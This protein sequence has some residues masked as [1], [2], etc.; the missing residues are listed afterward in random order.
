[1]AGWLILDGP[2]HLPMMSG[3]VPLPRLLAPALEAAGPTARL[4]LNAAEPPAWALAGGQG[5][6]FDPARAPSPVATP[7]LMAIVHSVLESPRRPF[8]LDWHLGERD[9]TATPDTR[10]RE[11]LMVVARAALESRAVAFAFDRERRPVALGPG[12][13]RKDSA[14]LM[15]VGLNLP[16]LLQRTGTAGDVELFL[17]KLAV[18][19]RLA[20]S[21]GVQKRQYLRQHPPDGLGRS[22]LQ[23]GF[24]LDR[25][26]LV[27]AP[28][29]LEETVRSLTGLDLCEH[30]TSL[31][32]GRRIVQ[33][34]HEALSTEGKLRLIDGVLDAAD[35]CPL[36]AGLTTWNKSAPAREQLRASG[37][38]HTVSGTGTAV[39]LLREEERTNPDEL[40]RLLEYAWEQ[41]AVA[42]V[43]FQPRQQHEH[44]P[45]LLG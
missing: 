12:L 21:A 16:G 3:A 11:L 20:V 24:L 43:R 10:Q 29:G 45:T 17:R 7:A 2:E 39:V 23:R 40:V 30:K 15:T 33:K 27:V 9:F 37:R 31:D 18:L 19:A 4:Q 42:K 36:P 34:L 13:D 35:H 14:V 41:T 22:F 6:L 32:V 38:L 44:Q 25:A 8:V 5:P 1:V 28:L 26:R